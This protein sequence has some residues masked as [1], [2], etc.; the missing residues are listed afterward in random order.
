[1]SARFESILSAVAVFGVCA[2]LAVTMGAARAE[3]ASAWSRDT[4]SSMR[5]IAGSSPPASPHL[6]A[7]IE[8]EL[9]PG[10]KTYW[11]YPG[12]SGVPP[13]FD[14]AGSDNVRAAKVLWPA[15]RVFNDEGG[16]VIGYKD[17]VIFP[18]EVTPLDPAKPV[19][20]RL[21]LDYAVCEKLCVPAEGRVA[22]AVG[23]QEK[24]H[25]AALTA[26]KALVPKAV[27]PQQA[28][29]TARRIDGGPRPLVDVDIA[30][31]H[32]KDVDLLVE[33][34]TAEW[35]LPIP[36][37]VQST[38]VGHRRFDF[39]LEGLPLG[40]DPKGPVEL[41]FTIL[42]AQGAIETTVRLD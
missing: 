2:A 6:R 10:W 29:L 4:R 38:P 13:R 12:D 28:G 31:A 19:T 26:A 14:F 32:G 22:I 5:L 20:L 34:P 23:R 37:S 35:A 15:P 16:T 33:G 18:L 36:K 25:D 1:M 27:S 7:G 9:A 30:A 24:T 17:K 39:E 21:K 11:R 41:T 40:V 3:D 8:I 42:D